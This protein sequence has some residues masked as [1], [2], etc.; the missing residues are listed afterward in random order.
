[1][2]R[3]N[4]FIIVSISVFLS[5]FVVYLY[6]RDQIAPGPDET[7][8][9]ITV[10]AYRID[11]YP[12]PD[13]DIYLNQRFIGR[14]D[15][16]GFF[17]TDM[18]LVVGE[19]YTIRVEKDRDGYQ[20][21]P[22]E[23]H[24]RVEPERK[25]RREKKQEEEEQLPS[26]E[27]E[28]DVLTELQRAE[29]GRVSPFEKY[30]FLAI[31]DGSMYYT[32]HVTGKKDAPVAD[33]SVTVNGKLEGRTDENGIFVVRYEG[34]DVQGEDIQLYKAGEHIWQKTVEISPSYELYI[35]LDTMLLIDLYAYTENYDVMQGIGGAEVYLN[36]VLVGRTGQSGYFGYRYEDEQGVEG[37]LELR[38]AYPPGYQPEE[39]VL[40][41]FITK[42]QP[43]LVH[44]DFSYP[45]V[46]IA[47]RIAVLPPRVS[48]PSNVL[49]ARR[50]YELKRGVEDYLSLGGVFSIVSDAYTAELFDRFELKISKGGTRW[51]DIP[52]LKN[53]VD[54]VIFGEIEPVGRAFSVRLYGIDYEGDIVGQLEG[55]FSLRDLDSLTEIFAEQFRGNFPFEGTISSVQDGI[56]INLGE[57]QGVEE[58]DKFYSFLNYYDDIKKD[59]SKKR[60]ARFSIDRVDEWYAVGKLESIS[61]GYLLEPG[62]KVKRFSEPVQGLKQIPISIVVTSGHSGLE[63]ANV[64]L[65]DQWI[66]Q[67][68]GEGRLEIVMT[69]SSSADVLVYKEGYIPEKIG[70]KVQE[71]KNGVRVQL[72]QGKTQ[73]TIDSEPRGALLFINGTF[74]GNTPFVREPIELPYGFHRIELRLDGYKDYNK[75]VKLSERRVSF[76]GSDRIILFEDYYH[77]AEV[78]YEQGNYEQALKILQSVPEAH[79]DFMR[80]LEFCGYIYLKHFEDYET[81]IA[82]YSRALDLH[83]P[84]GVPQAQGGAQRGSVV[85]YY[86]YGQACYN[87]AE[88]LYYDNSVEAQV[89]YKKAIDALKVVKAQRGRVQGSGR[90]SIYQDV[91][92]Y[93]AVSYQKLYYLSSLEEYLEQAYYSW[94]DY[95]DYFN[96]ELLEDDYFAKQYRIAE[97]Y[98]EEVK[99]LRSEK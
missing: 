17:K 11:R 33:A 75:Y 74:M 98:R 28:F 91:L 5:L 9:P 88:E 26:L 81:S 32:I 50:A 65:D 22:W 16:K 41:F 30:H 4:T 46:A 96:K 20:Y 42:E 14:T 67:T 82:C 53:T 97:S 54:G 47:P 27:G 64:Y 3:I 21:G 43:R 76:T 38:I 72:R 49:L 6:V 15:E 94:I 25:K 85:S 51:S 63:G 18:F 86:N 73:F 71:G 95:M 44:T 39:Q 87:R 7:V 8:A 80:S 66:G 61:E 36:Q 19:S 31:L 29:L 55:R 90:K 2:N 92:F 52:F 83:A 13:A 59:Y 62:S 84:G 24:F 68:D 10:E 58:N 77:Q 78:A 12:L 35:D 79:P 40:S 60:V 37:Y 1:M 56:A 93:L 57:R 34:E 89:L 48:D 70:I 69:E 23:T 45:T 99:R